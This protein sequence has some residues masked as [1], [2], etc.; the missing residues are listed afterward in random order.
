MAQVDRYLAV[1]THRPTPT[2][3][4]ER[5]MGPCITQKKKR[6]PLSDGG[7]DG[8][9]EATTSSSEPSQPE[10]KK[11]PTSFFG[12]K[13]FF[14]ALYPIRENDAGDAKRLEQN[15]HGHY[16]DEKRG[17]GLNKVKVE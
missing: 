17:Q 9:D 12:T 4:H 10:G 8:T 15:V 1:V 2:H 5:V 7:G 14:L 13:P 16:S 6:L 11:E 3:V